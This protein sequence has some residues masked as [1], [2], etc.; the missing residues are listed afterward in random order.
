MNTKDLDYKQTQLNNWS[1]KNPLRSYIIYLTWLNFHN[2][3][4][5]LLRIQANVAN[6]VN[7]TFSDDTVFMAPS[8]CQSD[9]GTILPQMV[10]CHMTL[11]CLSSKLTFLHFY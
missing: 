7:F 9:N 1:R 5:I 6:K 3:G 8:Q 11:P 4:L 10:N 2:C